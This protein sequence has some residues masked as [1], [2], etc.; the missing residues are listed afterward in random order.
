MFMEYS[1]FIPMAMLEVSA[2]HIL[3]LLP[4]D[5]EEWEV[6]AVVGC[7]FEFH[8]PATYLMIKITEFHHYVVGIIIFVVVAVTYLLLFSTGKFKGNQPC[9]TI[10]TTL[11]AFIKNNSYYIL[12]ETVWTVISSDSEAIDS[13]AIDSEASNP[14]AGD[15]EDSDREWYTP[16]H[17]LLDN[18]VFAAVGAA[19]GIVLGVI[20]SGIILPT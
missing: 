4:I 7:Q 15:P 20:I 6:N 2:N 11:L 18:V 3:L 13:E 19:L 10:T 8:T 5:N 12:L 1:K 9:R 14:E 17:S 16:P